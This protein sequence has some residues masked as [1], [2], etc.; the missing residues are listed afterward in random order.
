MQQAAGSLACRTFVD[1]L[2]RAAAVMASRLLSASSVFRTALNAGN[3]HS[4]AGH[5]RYHHQPDHPVLSTYPTKSDAEQH[6]IMSCEVGLQQPSALAA[7]Q[8]PGSIQTSILDS[9]QTVC[10]M[11]AASLT[12]Q[13]MPKCF[14]PWSLSG[15]SLDSRGMGSRISRQQSM[16]QS[17]LAG[18]S[19]QRS[20]IAVGI[21]G[22]VDSAVA[23]MLLKEQG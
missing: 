1:L 11:N 16:R 8:A 13:D 6:A 3:E 22:G 4:F 15:S 19:A 10:A 14:R 17:T 20:T 2:P 18:S 5:S 9:Q 23:A 21:S 12:E 7:Q